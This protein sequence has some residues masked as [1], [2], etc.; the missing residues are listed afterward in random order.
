MLVIRA[1][2]AGACYGVQR[3]LDIAWAQAES[4]G[5]A[6]SLGPLIHNPQ[7][8]QGL[9]RRGV[10]VVDE[11]PED[12]DCT[13]IVRSHGVGPDVKA[14][15]EASPARVADATCPYV[16]RAQRA[17]ADL[18][19]DPGF[20]VVVGE[21]QHPEV[22]AIRGYGLEAGGKVVVVDSADALPDELP[23]TVGVVVQTTQNRDVFEG[24]LSAI[25]ARGVKAVVRDTI[26]SAT[27]KR[28]QAARELASRVD[29]MVVIGGRNSSN[30][31]RLYEICSEACAK[32]YHI[33]W[34]DELE[35][36]WF[37]GCATVGVTAGASTP[38]DQI[39]PVMEYLE[40]L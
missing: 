19:R 11:V 40:R 13:V 1:E 14:K 22:A 18:A 38:E 5:K 20:V 35:A 25:R 33:E 24:V 8:V 26:C 17:S 4:G 39:A 32:T 34:V 9:A 23:E 36:A 15:L 2:A 37:D 7:V 30:T 27:S 10:N 3:A 12:A 31:T 29:A 16:L 28:Q 6:V 21:A